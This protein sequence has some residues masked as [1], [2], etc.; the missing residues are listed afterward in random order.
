M[1]WEIIN[2]NNTEEKLADSEDPHSWL[3]WNIQLIDIYAQFQK[4]V[5]AAVVHNTPECSS[6]ML[7]LLKLNYEVVWI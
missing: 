7:V 3:Q 5:S 2:N 1:A 4:I 6:I